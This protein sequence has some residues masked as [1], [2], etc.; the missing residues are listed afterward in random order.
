MIDVSRL[1]SQELPLI[2]YRGTKDEDGVWFAKIAP[3][4]GYLGWGR[5]E[6]NAIAQLW[7]NIG[8]GPVY[9]IR[10]AHNIEPTPANIKKMLDEAKR[11]ENFRVEIPAGLNENDERLAWLARERHISK[12]NLKSSMLMSQTWQKLG[13]I[14]QFIF[15]LNY[16]D[17]TNTDNGKKFG[18]DPQTYLENNPERARLWLARLKFPRRDNTA[19]HD[20]LDFSKKRDVSSL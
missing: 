17:G 10:G 7:D 8:Q 16:L 4:P 2:V 13:G 19:P 18:Q 3:L 12:Q 9:D 20:N 6:A 5:T 14:D 1:G 11:I 15:R